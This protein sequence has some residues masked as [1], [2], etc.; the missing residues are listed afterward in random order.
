[1]VKLGDGGG[2]WQ[3]VDFSSS[4]IRKERIAATLSIRL[5]SRTKQTKKHQMHVTQTQSHAKKMETEPNYLAQSQS[6]D[7]DVCGST[8]GRGIEAI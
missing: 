1:V 4:Q 2:N 8:P 3:E 5:N 7:D 6:C